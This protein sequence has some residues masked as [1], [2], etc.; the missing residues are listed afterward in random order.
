[1]YLKMTDLLDTCQRCTVAV[2]GIVSPAPKSGGAIANNLLRCRTCC[3][4]AHNPLV[5]AHQ[6]R[7]SAPEVS[8]V[9]VQCGQSHSNAFQSKNDVHD[10][11]CVSCP[12]LF[13]LQ[14]EHQDFTILRRQDATRLMARFNFLGTSW[15]SRA[16]TD[17]IQPI[18]LE[19]SILHKSHDSG[20]S[21]TL[22]VCIFTSK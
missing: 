3:P 16:L 14:R 1:M 20:S 18:I 6:G 17:F 13:S 10:F 22:H 4:Y 11:K 21:G 7:Q 9:H 5:I 2:Q 19:I 8:P 15:D 12:E